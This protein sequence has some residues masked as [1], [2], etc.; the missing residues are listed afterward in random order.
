MD[1][2]V[3]TIETGLENLREMLLNEG[4]SIDTNTLQGVRIPS[5]GFSNG[6]PQRTR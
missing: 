3:E 2:H 6:A 5:T 4:Y 1:N